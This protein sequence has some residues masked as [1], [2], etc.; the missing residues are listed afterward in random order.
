[1]NKIK[2]KKNTFFLTDQTCI[3]IQLY[4]NWDQVLFSKQIKCDKYFGSDTKREGTHP[5][6]IGLT[7]SEKRIMAKFGS[8]L[9]QLGGV[10]SCLHHLAPLLWNSDLHVL[11]LL[12]YLSCPVAFLA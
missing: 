10:L 9:G 7:G 8:S 5:S 2:I 12:F 1:M 6:W 11:S 3:T 4:M